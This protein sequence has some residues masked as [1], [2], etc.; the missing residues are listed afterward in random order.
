MDKS[1]QQQLSDKSKEQIFPTS[2]KNCR[3]KHVF[4]EK[5]DISIIEYQSTQN[6][7][8]HPFVQKKAYVR[9]IVDAFIHMKG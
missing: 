7:Q 4:V 9:I 3:K 1:T 5:I 8:N 6:D 2:N